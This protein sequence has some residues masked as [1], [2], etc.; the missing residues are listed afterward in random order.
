MKKRPSLCEILKRAHEGKKISVDGWIS[1]ITTKNGEILW[2]I[3]NG[4]DSIQ[5]VIRKKDMEPEQYIRANEINRESVVNIRGE[6]FPVNREYRVRV[7]DF[8]VLARSEEFPE[9]EGLEYRHLQVRRPKER[10]IMRITDTVLNTMREY[11]KNE[12]FIE[13]LPPTI[14]QMAGEDPATL[15]MT[16]YFGYPSYL[17]QTAQPYLE[18]LIT[19]V[20]KV[21]SLTPNYRR[22]KF[23]TKR[24]LSEF[25]TLEVEEA[26]ADINDM[27]CLTE[28]LFS[29]TV[30]TVADVNYKELEILRRDVSK[31]NVKPP[32]RRITYSEA[33]NKLKSLS[34]EEKRIETEWG[35]PFSAEEES[36]LSKLYDAPFFVTKFPVKTRPFHMRPD[37][38][39]PKL[40][41]SYDLFA[42]IAGEVVTGSERIID[43]NLL[44][45]RIN[46]YELP[47][48][49]YKWYLELRKYGL[50]PHAGFGVGMERL[51]MNITGLED[52]KY[53]SLFPRIPDKR[54]YP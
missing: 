32:F 31:L 23:K 4:S 45:K 6:L 26:F 28:N 53:V 15:F 44:L 18:A 19:S 20:G 13:V 17:S 39:N 7:K 51:L 33:V 27:M 2:M 10:A 12:G 49:V 34:K 8:H 3:R 37:P 16:Q 42:P 46:E 54:P 30:R 35:K 21:W 9:D 5:A 40:T 25:W 50:P 36:I 47:L 29:E 24:H 1:E 43:Y 38:E 11:L 52:I 41:L 22:E 48:S 14:T